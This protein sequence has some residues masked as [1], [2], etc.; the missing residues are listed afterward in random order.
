M[1]DLR[2]ITRMLTDSDP[3]VRS[4]II[5]IYLLLR[6]VEKEIAL[7]RKVMLDFANN[8]Q[9]FVD[10]NEMTLQR[11]EELKRVGQTPG[12]EVSSIPIVDE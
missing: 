11:L 7:N 12:V 6:E 3:K 1:L 5:D 8:M 4:V 9:S 10:L 2:D